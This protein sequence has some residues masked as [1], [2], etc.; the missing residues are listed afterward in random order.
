MT[1]LEPGMSVFDVWG[2][3]YEVVRVRHYKHVT[4]GYR[5]EGVEFGVDNDETIT[6]LPK[7]A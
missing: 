2:R 7:E 3:T 1:V 4:L 6:V 5:A